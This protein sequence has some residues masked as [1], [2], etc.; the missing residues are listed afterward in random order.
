MRGVQ[1]WGMDISEY[2]IGMVQPELK[3]YCRVGL[4]LE[5]LDGRYDMITSIEVLEHLSKDDG[6]IAIR[7]M[8]QH[9]DMILFTST[10]NDFAEPTHLNVQ[11]PEYWVNKFFMNGFVLDINYDASYLTQWAMLFRRAKSLIGLHSSG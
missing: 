1:A 5:P 3:P 2:A 9:T 8:C 11:P 10:P 6:S 7:N 4:I